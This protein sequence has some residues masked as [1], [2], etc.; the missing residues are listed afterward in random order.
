MIASIIEMEETMAGDTPEAAGWRKFAMEAATTAGFQPGP[1]SEVAAPT[2][3]PGAPHISP[4]FDV[5]ELLPERAQDRLRK[6]RDRSADAHAVCVPFADIQEASAARIAA[7][8][9]LRLLTSH[10]QEFGHGLPSTDNRVVAQQRLVNKLTDDFRRLQER[11]E[12]R[13]AAFQAA[14]QAQANVETWLKS[15]RPGGTTLLDHDGP[16]PKLLKGE[17]VIDAIERLRR[18]G[19]ELKADLHRIESAPFPS[20]YAKQRMRQMIEQLAQRG[21]PDVSGLIELDRD[22]VW[23]TLRQQADVVS[24]AQRALAFH[25]AVD[26]VGLAAFLLKPTLISA[27]DALVDEESDD[28]NSLTHEA[29]QQREAEVMG[30]LLSVERE[31]SALVW[32]AQ[33]QNLP[34][35][36]R[37][38]ISPVALLGLKLITTP[39]ATNAASTPE[40]ASFDLAGGRR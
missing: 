36:F 27:L 19:R 39:R 34:C 13:A 40:L 14:S 12:T 16:E 38:D 33:S 21:Q 2:P 7:E 11:S 22:I 28:A 25:E 26:V 3:L 20:S 32:L 23:A 18:R 15:G 1:I 10:P 17:S 37:H 24:T 6:L 5:I 30:D 9:R 35:E 8:N 29:R 4:Q 31:E